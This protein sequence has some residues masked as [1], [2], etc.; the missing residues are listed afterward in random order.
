M[1]KN[2]VPPWRKLVILLIA[3]LILRT[4]I[5]YMW[6]NDEGTTLGFGSSASMISRQPVEIDAELLAPGQLVCSRDLMY[7]R[8]KYQ[9]ALRS[10][11]WAPRRNRAQL[12]Q[13]TI[14]FIG[15]V[16][17]RYPQVTFYRCAGNSKKLRLIPVRW[18]ESIHVKKTLDTD[19]TVV[20][21][22]LS[23][24]ATAIAAAERGFRVV[25]L[26]AGP[27]GGLSS[28]TGGN[29]R[30]FD[31]I[32]PTTHPQAQHILFRQGLRIS[33]WTAIPLDVDSRLAEYLAQKYAGR[34]T[35]IKTASYD[36]IH[37]NR[38]GNNLRDVL[39]QEGCRIRSRRYIDMDPE[40][41]V[42]EK[43]G[44]A[45]DTDTQ[46]LSYG[47][48]FDVIGLS[49]ADW[50]ALSS[51]AKLSA[52]TLMTLAGVSLSE[53][54]AKP[55][56]ARSYKLLQRKLQHDFCRDGGCYR[57]GYS[58]LA[59]GFNF[60]MQCRGIAEPQNRDL[61]W[62]NSR[63]CVSG[64]NIGV[65][66]DF[67]NFNSVSYKFRKS[68]LQQSH[69][70]HSDT[71]FAPICHT[72]APA[73]QDYFRYVTGNSMLTVRIPDQFYIRSASAFFKTLHPYEPGEFN[74]ES[75]SGYRTFYPMDLRDLSARDRY[76]WRT[77]ERYIKIAR[78]KHLWSC[79]P[80]ATTTSV[81]NL[82]IVNKCGVTPA[83]FGGQRIEGNQT[84]MGCALVNSFS[85]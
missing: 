14:E 33:N 19:V 55:D 7:L 29:L 12:M 38:Q 20:G 57:Y 64:F 65:Y 60:Y 44:V 66:K 30:F 28:D 46:H 58:A 81:Q 75:G 39:T 47:L 23:S 3:M 74:H 41:R 69:S 24:L 21:A 8:T 73:L 22:E 49:A 70:L 72:E 56:S 6:R 34:I 17:R 78:G 85:R 84:N 54:L 40:A 27:L 18:E 43:R 15:D 80:S 82:Y 32:A 51:H 52:D 31:N 63:R 5:N 48:V 9:R 37:V 1:V 68:Y 50:E 71:E 13:N 35:L 2:R 4:G 61:R 25:V 26:Y 76:S 10:E 45:M 83:F 53:V 11:N 62:L 59:Q 42:T 36:S 79:R 67:A 16:R 77:I